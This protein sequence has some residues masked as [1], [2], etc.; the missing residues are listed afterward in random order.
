[1]V[2]PSEFAPRTR[3]RLV[4]GCYAIG[5]LLTA[6]TGVGVRRA[7]PATS[8]IGVLT[9]ANPRGGSTW[10]T[11]ASPD[12]WVVRYGAPQAVWTVRT[13]LRGAPQRR[14]HPIGVLTNW[15]FYAA[16]VGGLMEAVRWARRRARAG[17]EAPRPESA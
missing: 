8:S 13:P 14:L 17:A 6:A 7:G 10:S 15:V 2:H 11:I 3:R 12:G 1:M 5:A 9:V 4:I 16:I